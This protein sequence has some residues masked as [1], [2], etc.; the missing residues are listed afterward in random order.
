[1]ST[2]EVIATVD[3]IVRNRIKILF[4]SPERLASAAFRRLFRGCHSNKTSGDSAVKSIP[5]VSL[6][7]VDECHCLSTWGHNFR[8]SYLRIKSLLPI[9]NPAGILALTATACSEVISD[10]CSTLGISYSNKDIADQGHKSA[11]IDINLDS[12]SCCDE[13]GVKV[14]HISRKNIDV[15]ACFFSSDEARRAIVRILIHPATLS[16]R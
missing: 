9:M 16:V 1:M 11:T 6:L 8:P 5:K 15:S 14:L 3:D 4:V 12:D 7:C 2:S 13:S 10:V